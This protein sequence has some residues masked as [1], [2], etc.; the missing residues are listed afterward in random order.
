MG[1]NGKFNES[2]TKEQIVFFSTNL[3]TK[4]AEGWK[5]GSEVWFEFLERERVA[6]L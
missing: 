4:R 6:S 3:K 5:R 2:K 1:I